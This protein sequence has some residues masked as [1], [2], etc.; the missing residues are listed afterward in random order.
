M[1]MH[2]QFTKDE[3]NLTAIPSCLPAFYTLAIPMSCYISNVLVFAV[4]II[5]HV[6]SSYSWLWRQMYK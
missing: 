6:L 3:R 2:N 1:N 5:V 4:F